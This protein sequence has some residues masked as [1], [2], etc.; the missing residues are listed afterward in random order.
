MMRTVSRRNALR[1][2]GGIALAL[3]FLELFSGATAHAQQ[4]MPKRFVLFYHHQ[5]T[6][7]RHWAQPGASETSYQLGEILSP[8]E[9]LDPLG[10]PWKDRCL[11]LYG[12]DNKIARIVS[13]SGH[14]AQSTVL[15]C[16][17][18]TTS[19]DGN[20]NL[21]PTSQQPSQPGL[22]H[23]IGPS[24]DQVLAQRLRNNHPYGSIDVSVAENNSSTLYAGANDPVDSEPDPQAVF[25]RYFAN[26][27][28]SAE[29]LA[30]LR[31][32]KLS[33][34]DAVND[35][36]A[37]LRARLGASDRQR[38]DAHADKIR[39]LELA[40]QNARECSVPTLSPAVGFDYQN[41]EQEGARLQLDLLTMAMA[42]DLAPVGSCIFARGH[43]PTW[44]WIT[45]YPGSIE[46]G[47]ENWHDMVH[48][49][50]NMGP[51]ADQDAPGLIRGY[52]WYTEQ[53]V[54][55]LSRLHATPEDGGTMLDNSVVLWMSEFGN[56]TGHNSNRLH[57]VLAGAVG[58]SAG[59]GR[60]LTLGPNGDYGESPNSTNQVF[61]SLLN[62]FGF[63]DQTF[64]WQ[65]PGVS[66]GGIS[67]IV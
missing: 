33:V 53:F 54:E 12:V 27:L 67:G 49:G 41:D 48:L 59:T 3:P 61:V 6:I 30:R 63:A 14:F 50:R 32:R 8:L 42:C 21:L 55:L 23:A 35:N 17:V 22:Y 28:Q 26:G 64:G 52:K 2:A 39:E 56:G 29:E 31:L 38:L 58:G 36:F 34:L 24:I 40:I 18:H 5:G 13:P 62:T 7:L 20:G 10:N 51:N 37:T 19:I 11:F 66:P 60:C 9:G 57:I 1:G 25:D 45:D 43:D 65:A 47:Y 15:T 4:G 46:T 44:T 16:Q